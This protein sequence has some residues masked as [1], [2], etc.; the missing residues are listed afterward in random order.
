VLLVAKSPA[1]QY[2]PDNFEQGTAT[3]TLAEVG[4]YQRLLNY[5]WTNGSVPGDSMKAL[6][7][8]MRCTPATA[9]SV[10][11]Q[12]GCKF[13]KHA[14]GHWR[15]AKMESVRAE[16]DAYRELQAAKGRASAAARSN[17][18]STAVQPNTQP[19][20]NSP[21]PSP[22]PSPRDQI[23]EQSDLRTTRETDFDRFWALYPKKTGKDAAL[24]AWQKARGKPDLLVILDAVT[25]QRTS[26]QWLKD[27]G[28]FI[29]NPA[30]WINQ[31][32]WDDEPV[33][34]PQ[35][36]EKNARSLGAIYGND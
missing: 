26:M 16:Q 3:F 11:A 1:F 29:P 4:G 23:K 6:S 8:I 10:W 15:N 27:G 12:I 34:M 13:V 14:D 35:V 33:D 9:K 24:R 19:E 28:Q 2:Y 18:T 30:T 36:S 22:S 25:Q 32:R 20:V 17:R 31:G 7:Q 21:S 5:Q